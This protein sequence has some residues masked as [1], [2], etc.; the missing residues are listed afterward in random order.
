MPPHHH[1]HHHHHP[2]H[3]ASTKALD[4]HAGHTPE[5]FRNRF[6]VSLLLTLPILY[7]SE[8]VRGLL[9]LPPLEGASWIPL[10][11]GTIIYFYGG[12]VFL[13][14]AS[15]ELRGRRPGMMTLVALGIT[16]AFAYS[17]AVELGL[18]GKP[19]WWELATLVDVMLLGH[20]LEMKAILG[21]GEALR[22]LAKLMPQTAHR[23]RD[24]RI[25]D[26]PTEALKEGDL[27]LIRPGEQVPADGVVVEGATSMNEA[28]LTGESRPVAKGVGDE[29]LAGALNGEGAIVVRVTR[30]G[31]STTLGQIMRLVEEAQ[32]SRSRFQDLGERVAG[33]LFYV[34]VL[35][36]SLTF[37]FWI[38][39]GE[40]LSF[41]LER[42]V[43]VVIIACPHALGL[44][45]PL[46]V[47]NAT[48]MAAQRGILIRNREAFERA[49]GLRYVALDKT[50]TL[51]EGQFEVRA[52]YAD[53]LG[54][55]EALTLAAALEALSE[56]P[57]A[58]AI[59]EAAKERGLPL[60]S[61]QDFR[62]IPGKGVEGRV[63]RR[64]YRVGRP[65][66]AGELGLEVPP[67][68]RQGLEEA[69]ARGESVV[70][71]MDES[72]VLAYL[73]LRDRLRPT[74]KQ[75]IDAL[76]RMGITPV[77]LTG[78]A[79]AVARTVARELGIER[80][81]ARVLPQ[82]KA[83]IVRELKSQGPTAFVGD[84]INDAPALLEADLGV[85]IGAGTNVAIESADV[86]LVK[87]DP[88]D[89]VRLLHLAR[90]TR[91]KMLQNLFWATGYNIVA[92][93]LAAGAA[94]PF[95]GLLLPPALGALFMSLS[96]V[97]VALNALLLRRARLDT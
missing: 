18:K 69:E 41:A 2:S 63:E 36:G 50:G 66:W 68:L 34:A 81:R 58:Q 5:M 14:G 74:A 60:P 10:L 49:T 33:W 97:V 52:V 83:R 77:M 76:K 22:A 90:A 37:I 65:E 35:G 16:V 93:P 57:L 21:A 71:L 32:V 87:S 62:A 46:V 40:S 55:Q 7:V 39:S 42:A 24:G 72:R 88:L 51:T 26:V 27:I 84:G 56:H 4:R 70:A 30:T 92:L 23:L 48:A 73:A 67:S 79:E 6:L 11:L 89:V 91:R 1:H 96:T 31:T 45:I 29:V 61:V 54:E 8:E 38:A 13:Q 43:T 94:Y 17:L 28:F 19:F 3:T 78:D 59:L 20:F 9:G 47:V 86:V 95:F 82:D 25:E 80:Y 15:R 44:A 12:G 53:G 64:L 85:A 75:A